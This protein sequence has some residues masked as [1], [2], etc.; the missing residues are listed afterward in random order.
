VI[1][2]PTGHTWAF[3]DEGAADAIVSQQAP[4]DALIDRLRGWGGVPGPVQVLDAELLRRHGWAWAQRPRNGR[5]VAH[6]EAAQRWNVEMTTNGSR[7]HGV[8][9]AARTVALEGC[10]R[11]YGTGDHVQIEYQLDSV[12]IVEEGTR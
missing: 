6:D 10:G 2:L 3:V 1:D 11:L 9:S 7:Y 4:A 12:E 5:V 8:V